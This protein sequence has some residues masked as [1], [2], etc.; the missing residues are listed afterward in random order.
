MG[1]IK[2][3]LDSNYI[4]QFSLS[5]WLKVNTTDIEN[6]P[7]LIIR[8]EDDDDIEKNR[9]NLYLNRKRQIVLNLFGTE[10]KTNSGKIKLNKYYHICLGFNSGKMNIFINS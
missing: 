6:I 3:I 5:F 9:I 4:T 1:D 8:N 10:I 7:I 2:F